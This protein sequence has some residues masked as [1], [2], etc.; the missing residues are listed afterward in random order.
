MEE[1]I[2][3]E[4]VAA[5][6][7]LA[8][9]AL[10]AVVMAV[11][12]G[13][14]HRRLGRGYLREWALAWVAIAVAQSAAAW[15][16]AW[17]PE[18]PAAHPARLAATAIYA[19]GGFWYAAWLLFGATAI[20][21]GR[22]VSRRGGQAILAAL[23]VLGI[24]STL[25]WAFD[26]AAAELRHAVRVGVRS[27]VL[28]AALLGA[29][30]V[31]GRVARRASADETGPG[32]VSLAFV[33]KG[34][35]QLLVFLS[36]LGVVPEIARSWMTPIEFLVTATLGLG[37]VVWLLEEEQHQLREA[38]RQ[39]ERLAFYDV[40]T[41][42]PNR[43]L[44]V[45]RLRGWLDRAGRESSGGALIFLDL[46]D[47]RAVND[48][49]GHESGDQLLAAFSGRLL[50][51]VREGDILGRLGAD[52]FAVVLPGVARAA[53][54]ERAATD[55][56]ERLRQPLKVEDREV[57]VPASAGIA[58]FPTDGR[59]PAVLLRKADSALSRA[60]EV[61]RGGCVLYDE[62]LSGT[63][64]ERFLLES[65][66]RE[67]RLEG[68]L[69]LH[70]QP[71]VRSGSGEIV[72]AEAL[73]RWRHPDRGLLKPSE[74]LFAAESAAVSD[75]ISRWVVA[76]ACREVAGWRKRHQSDLK[77]A[78]NLTA[79]AFE[80]RR[81]A[82]AVAGILSETGL[83]AEALELEITETMA[84]LQVSDPSS[85]LAEIRSRGTRVAV[86]DFGTGYSSLSYLREL[87][88]EIVKLDSSFIRDLGRRPRDSRIVGAVIQLAHGLGLEVVA[89]GVEEEGQMAVLE[90]LHCDRMQ[91]F[92]FSRPL[93][94]TEFEALLESAKPFRTATGAGGFLH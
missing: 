29:G 5:V 57:I 45:D 93:P 31:L 11:L 88:I 22:T 42:L 54:A 6:A 28:G 3:A 10:F 83:P 91:G 64:R 84:L 13:R 48:R 1:S 80:D 35:Q 7:G 38:S 87:P 30:L 26:P 47:F 33:A 89:E 58:L 50:H 65:A 23:A 16:T 79:R 21:S 9:Q 32:F 25:L 70:Y 72:G 15:T 82:D 81:L 73:L 49:F 68:S 66:L 17:M 41:G 69:E 63:A 36:V 94:A 40:I 76:T 55:L 56:L 43:K 39:I 2:R 51:S 18:L 27:L 60:K 61:V 19:V 34:A 59:D 4:T 8:A 85:I 86:D 52:E 67:G 46:D 75:A 14:F 37:T 77:V 78:V 71:I 90:M 12:L 20:A 53:E 44:F 74:F 62:A 92:L 24:A